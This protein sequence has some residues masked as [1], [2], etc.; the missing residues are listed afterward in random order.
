MTATF[1]NTI[2]RALLA[3]TLRVDD[4]DFPADQVTGLSIALTPASPADHPYVIYRDGSG[5]SAAAGKPVGCIADITP[6]LV[7]AAG[8]PF[9]FFDLHRVPGLAERLQKLIGERASSDPEPHHHVHEHWMGGHAEP[10]PSTHST[11]IPA[12]TDAAARAERHRARGYRVE[13]N[14]LLGFVISRLD[15]ICV[16]QVTACHGPACAPWANGRPPA[17]SV[18][19]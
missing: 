10:A 9:T 11:L 15:D 14:P 8:E 5:T 18:R 7:T 6:L 1:I 19:R 3:G 2:G 16:V 17:D 13:G 12:P 4:F